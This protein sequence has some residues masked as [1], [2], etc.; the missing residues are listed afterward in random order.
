MALQS[1]PL[2]E[3]NA[4]ERVSF[5]VA[6]SRGLPQSKLNEV[7]SALEDFAQE[8]PGVGPGVAPLQMAGMQVGQGFAIETAEASR[9]IA[10]PD[11]MPAWAVQAVGNLVQV[12]CFEY[13][14]FAEVWTRARRY[15]LRALSCIDEDAPVAEVA[16]HVV[17]KFEYPQGAN[18]QEYELAELFNP[19]SIYLTPKAQI[20]GALWHVYQG[21][22]E[23]H[24]GARILHQLNLSTSVV[25]PDQQLNAIIDHRGALRANGDS[26]MLAFKPLV[27]HRDD[28]SVQL[29]EAFLTLRTHNRQ[30]IENLL[31]PKKLRLIGIGQ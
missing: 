30:A 9:F 20:S 31:Q 25:L 17:D 3:H 19:A 12:Q 18:W 26:D 28:G 4:I 22:F 29:D 15:L 13:T 6:F 23:P 11:G 27:A 21:W 8:L 24:D 14:S 2:K 7:R 16:F 5:V 1:K 10:K